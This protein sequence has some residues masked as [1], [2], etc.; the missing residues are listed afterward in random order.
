MSAQKILINKDGIIIEIDSSQVASGSPGQIIALTDNGRIDSSVYVGGVP[1]N[2]EF[3]TNKL[4]TFQTVSDDVHYPSEKL[5]RDSLNQ[6]VSLSRM[7]SGHSLSGD[8][9][10]NNVDV[11]LSNVLNLDQTNPVNI[12]QDA[13]HRFM[14]DSQLGQL[15]EETP[16]D[17]VGALI[18]MY[19][20]PDDLRVNDTWNNMTTP[21]GYLI[22]YAREHLK[23]P[24]T[25]ILNP[26]SGPGTVV[27]ENY[28]VAITLLQ[29]ANISCTGYI[30][31][32]GRSVND[33]KADMDA[34]KNLYPATN[35]IF[36]DEMPNDG[37]RVA[38]FMELTNY[39]H[40]KMFHPIIGNPGTQMPEIY[41]NS[42]CADIF[43]I[44]ENS[45]YPSESSLFG[46]T[47]EG[48]LRDYDYSKFAALVYN[49]SLDVNAL[50]M[51]RKYV[52]YV[53]VT[54]D[55]LPNPWDTLSSSMEQQLEVLGNTINYYTDPKASKSITI[56]GYSLSGNINLTKSDVTLGNVLNL[57]QTN[58]ANITQDATHRFATDAQIAT[59]NA[60]GS[61]SSGTVNITGDQTIDGNKTFLKD[62]KANGVNIGLGAG[63]VNTNISLGSG[64]LYSNTTGAYNIAI[65]QSTLNVNTSGSNNIAIG[66]NAMPLNTIGFSNIAVGWTSMSK[67]TTGNN[68]I[69]IGD[70]SLL[71]NV[72]GG[73]NIGIGLSS[74]G[75]NTYGSGNI[76]I[77][78]MAGQNNSYGMFNTA[79]GYSALKLNASGSNNIAIGYLAIYSS[80]SAAS[81]NIAIGNNAMYGNLVSNNLAIG[82]NA[83]YATGTGTNNIA[84]GNSVLSKNTNGSFNTVI[85]TFA[86]SNNTT[87][88]NNVAVG[89]RALNDNTTGTEN[90]AIGSTALK[91]NATGSYN[92]AIGFA[93]LLNNVTSHNT[94]IGYQALY[95]NI[96]GGDNI[97]IGGQALYSNT[98]GGSNV[99]MGYGALYT[100]T[101]GQENIA[102]G[103]Q[104]MQQ[105]TEGYSNVAVGNRA[106]TANTTGVN[107]VAI[108]ANALNVNQI[109]KQNIAL[110]T[111]AL[112]NNIIDDNIAMGHYALFGNSVG[113]G[114]IGIGTN[115]L[116]NNV[117]NNNIALGYKS[118]YNNTTGVANIA[119]GTLALNS[120]VSGKNNVA[121]GTNSLLM[122]STGISNIAI[123]SNALCNVTI[124]NRNIAI[125]NDAIKSD[126]GATGADNIALGEQSLLGNT[127]G[128]ANVSIGSYTLLSNTTGAHN[129]AIGYQVL[130]DNTTG[131]NNIAIGGYVLDACTSG[132]Y[133]IGIGAGS[134]TTTTVGSGN[135]G[136]GYAALNKVNGGIN[137]TA[138]GT[139]AAYKNTADNNTVFGAFALQDNTSGINLT[140]VGFRALQKSTGGNN[141]AIG[142]SALLSVVTGQYNTAIGAFADVDSSSSS[143]RTALGYGAICLND[144]TVR[145][146]RV[147]TDTLRGY[148]YTADSDIR[149]KENIQDLSL[150]LNFI[151]KLRPVSYKWKDKIVR[152]EEIK[153]HR[154]HAGFIAQEIGKTLKDFNTDLGLYQ[155]SAI[156]NK[157]TNEI[158]IDFN[159]F[160]EPNDLKGYSPE[161]LLAITVKAIQELSA[162]V[163]KLETKL[164]K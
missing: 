135:I 101:I 153:Y 106:L 33:I 18:P 61:G 50:N 77:G 93:A 119:V 12:V 43:V 129:V 28:S 58:P 48:T 22:K 20:Y 40:L 81:G 59:W 52:G 8:I 143:A 122:M 15:R 90:V 7:I 70:L 83:L 136:I 31:T 94:A 69:A 150:G 51:M 45:S 100:N 6:K 154:N 25:T 17:G 142:A 65:G 112:A 149:L 121:I 79:L 147:S 144:N 88:A 67:N 148:N 99:A 1:G 159:D 97:A 62:I 55:D 96:T 120:N 127:T 131:N 4:A 107:N 157:V 84:I 14:T 160:K 27:D 138:T 60:G 34:W 32:L 2:A 82:N 26:D 76:A 158:E 109:G 95:A 63:N 42:G 141:T 105:N 108:G 64:S 98:T 140:A 56:N 66:Q 30:P 87:S 39:G 126:I 53:Y 29:G 103:G 162:K 116:Y 133:N 104:A 78:Y 102:L 36:L 41:Y 91:N 49:Q 161:Q 124:S 75:G 89:Y 11:G 3:S 47:W 164:N 155:D 156:G 37:S 85:G 115:T 44:Y 151:N 145:C 92:T 71:N 54:E 111:D 123:G 113:S 132:A 125:G 57:D 23:V 117:A 128:N 118:L 114:N 139:F 163:K 72:S 137:N 35:G 152:G 74:L 46:A 80:S 73:Y 134:L 110:G 38:D 16:L 5:L 24:V 19:I 146:G 68:N 130:H 10:L 13:T 21:Y 9:T 86:M